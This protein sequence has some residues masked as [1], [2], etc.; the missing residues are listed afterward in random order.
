MIEVI[1][2]T[3]EDGVLKPNGPLNLPAHCRVRLV[4]QPLEEGAE[5]QRRQAWEA[6]ER[7]WQ[8]STLDSQGTRLS[9]DE[10][11]ERR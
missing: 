11:H 9:R 7:L 4:V 8:Q 6:L 1:T 5:E 10:L 3:F 2:A